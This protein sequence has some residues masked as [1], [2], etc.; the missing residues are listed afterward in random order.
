MHGC[1]IRQKKQQSQTTVSI[2]AK[3]NQIINRDIF[4]P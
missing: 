2:F 4:A 1:Y 3:K